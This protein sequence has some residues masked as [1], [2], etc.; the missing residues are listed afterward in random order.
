MKKL[1]TENLQQQYKTLQRNLVVAHFEDNVLPHLTED[2]TLYW[3]MGIYG[4]DCLINESESLP[5]DLGDSIE[6]CI[7]QIFPFYNKEIDP[8]Y[9]YLTI[10][11]AVTNEKEQETSNSVCDKLNIGEYKLKFM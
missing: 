9:M 8:V 6:D 11:D 7:E 5:S 3:G 2:V 1:Y 10:L 4:V